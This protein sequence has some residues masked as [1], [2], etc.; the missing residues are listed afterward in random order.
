MG[1]E[2]LALYSPHGFPIPKKRESESTLP[3]LGVCLSSAP[4]PAQPLPK[5]GQ[6][7]TGPTCAGG[8]DLELL[9]QWVQQ[10]PR[11]QLALACLSPAASWGCCMEE[12]QVGG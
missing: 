6:E 5:G 9:H 10:L 3:G 8:H 1:A 4:L 12:A 7:G 2:D 11:L